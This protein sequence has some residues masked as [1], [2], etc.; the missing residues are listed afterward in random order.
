MKKGGPEA[1][2]MIWIRMP[3]MEMVCWRVTSDV[4]RAVERLQKLRWRN[5]E[6]R[7]RS[8]PRSA[9]LCGN[10]AWGGCCSAQ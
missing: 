9:G 4:E 8:P 2:W 6:C 1:A 10:Y 3:G 7:G 5:T